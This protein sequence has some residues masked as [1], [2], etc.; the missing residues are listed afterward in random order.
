MKHL[1]LFCLITFFLSSCGGG[2]IHTDESG[3]SLYKPS[4]AAGFALG[5]E[6]ENRILSIKNSWQKG[7]AGN[8]RYVIYPRKDSLLHQ[9][10]AGHIPWPVQNAVCL[11]TTHIAYLA[12]LDRDSCISGVS[13]AKYVSNPKIRAATAS[14][15]IIDV[16]YEAGLN[17]ETLLA[18]HPDVV[19]AYGISGA[20]NAFLEPLAKLGLQVVYISDYLETHP[21]GKAEYLLAFAAFFE[22]QVIEKAKIQFED[23]CH[24][25]TS[26]KESVRYSVRVKVL[27]NAPYKDVWYIPGGDNYLT[28]LFEDAGARVLGSRKGIKESHTVSLEQACLYALEADYWLHP[29]AFRT[30]HA[31]S[32]HD[33]RFAQMPAFLSGRV[34]NNTRRNTPQGGSDFWETGVTE[35][36]L[37]LADLISIFHP[38]LLPN[39]PLKYYEPLN[40]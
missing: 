23:I 12:A 18:L 36:Q 38:D 16:G 34:Y 40:P 30:L 11:S 5:K 25:Y 4:Y 7:A 22:P 29:N 35:P 37:L 32:G 26:L 13:G 15:A 21:L 17:Y 24:Q 31:L 8:F 10:K 6:G 1:I 20:S 14:N 33:A 2:S 3:S 39:H 19:F 28:Q 9:G 27:L